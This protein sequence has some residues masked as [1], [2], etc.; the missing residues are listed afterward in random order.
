MANNNNIQLFNA[1]DIEKYHKGLLSNIQM[2]ELE[3]AALDDPFLADALDGYAVPGVNAAT[4]IASLKKLLA[5]KTEQE[6]TPV[7]SMGSRRSGF[8]WFRAAAAVVI[9]GSAGLLANQFLFTKKDDNNIAQ[10]KN[11]SAENK[12]SDSVK[13]EVKSGTVAENNGSTTT[14]SAVTT[15]PA[16]SNGTLTD[17][18]VADKESTT[19]P[20]GNLQNKWMD[21]SK[22]VAANS[23]EGNVAT[24][25]NTPAPVATETAIPSTGGRADSEV[26]KL[27]KPDRAGQDDLK[28]M[29]E[30]DVAI[31]TA[32]NKARE[33]SISA[34]ADNAQKQANRS[35]AVSRRTEEQNYRNQTNNVFRGRITDANNVGVPYANV[36]NVE[37]KAGTYADA[38]GYFNLTSPD[39]VL[40]VQV[41]SIGFENTQTQL[42]NNLPANKVV[43]Q[44]DRK[45]LSEV[46]ISKQK[47]NVAA[48][49]PDANK[50]LE[51][52]IPADGWDSYNTY[53]ANNLEIPEDIKTKKTNAGAVEVSFEVDKN[54]EPVNIRV[55]K[56][57]CGKCDQEAIRLI[58]E[59][60]KWKRTANK[61]GRTTVT[62]NF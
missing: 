21:K 18:T 52:P 4:D 24:T 40:T 51:E 48:R 50:T 57:L 28:K 32:D 54:G 33:R 53:A 8:P 19:S 35:V 37:D 43:L 42:R 13:P 5:A 25:T 2:H 56:S 62:I 36:T 30:K 15:T 58:K 60:P 10:V 38:N 55:E 46:V 20:T 44:D 49:N 23:K 22:E 39:S 61:K 27:N 29:S 7:I 14:N 12:S 41:R 45:S 16:T 26:A 1:A 9:I 3:K 34:D 17:V 31:V 11:L 6:E 47:P 59:G